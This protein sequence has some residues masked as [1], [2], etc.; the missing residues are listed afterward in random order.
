M[1]EIKPI[2]FDPLPI[3]RAKATTVL[4]IEQEWIDCKHP[5]IVIVNGRRYLPEDLGA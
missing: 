4:T 2:S 3:V 1:D 5:D